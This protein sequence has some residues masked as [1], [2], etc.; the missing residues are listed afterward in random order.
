MNIGKNADDETYHDANKQ[1][2]HFKVR[3]QTDWHHTKWSGYKK[4]EGYHPY[5][6]KDWRSEYLYTKRDDDAS[7][8]F[9]P[10]VLMS[11]D[12]LDNYRPYVY[13]FLFGLTQAYVAFKYW[14]MLEVEK[15][16][17][18]ILSSSF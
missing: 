9:S 7:S 14:A 17:M 8:V 15:I 12:F 5:N 11:Y 3:T 16:E 13:L 1:S 2:N 10:R 4:P 18:Q 6:G